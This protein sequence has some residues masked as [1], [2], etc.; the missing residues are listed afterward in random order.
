M[1]DPRDDEERSE[2]GQDALDVAVARADGPPLRLRDVLGRTRVA[3]GLRPLTAPALV[4]VPIGAALGPAGL[5]WLGADVLVRLYPVIAVALAA[6]GIFV[7]LGL[8]LDAPSERTLLRAASIEAVVTT[9]IVA[10]GFIVLL[11]AWQAPLDLGIVPF[12]LVLG[13]AAAA[14]AAGATSPADS[15]GRRIAM[16]LADLDDV[17]PVAA[18]GLVLAVVAV[19]GGPWPDVAQLYLLNVGT[20]L[21]VALAGWLL[22]ER[23][24]GAAERG[25]FVVGVVTLL[26]GLAFYLGVSALLAG[27]VA[28]LCWRELPG[29]A[30]TMIRDDLRRLQHP[31]VVVLLVFAGASAQPSLLALWLLGPYV[32][33]RIAGKLAGS[34]LL[35][36]VV[37]DLR[38][39]DLSGSFFLPPGVIGLAFALAFHHVHGTAT[40]AAAVTAVAAGTLASEIIAALALLGPRR[41]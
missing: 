4:L 11:A 14:S 15:H 20:A 23:E 7:G 5:S 25:V 17:L 13:L 6:L 41:H 10:G 8:R 30:D 35:Q 29:H 37:P 24:L 27:M 28:G 36:R 33:L 18:G 1:L 21:G 26:G 9:A 19:R 34:A 40:S 38:A 12:A 32:L 31:L 2:V 22:F 39:T 16:R 3:L